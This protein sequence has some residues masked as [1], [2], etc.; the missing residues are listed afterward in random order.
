MASGV[1]LKMKFD[2]MR[3]SRTWTYNNANTQATAVQV[4]A[5]GQAMITNGSI[6]EAVPVKLVS[7]VQ[8]TT[9][10]MQYDVSD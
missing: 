1:A 4:K 2:T 9:S 3:G 7:A 6:Y 5:L 10:E 8:V